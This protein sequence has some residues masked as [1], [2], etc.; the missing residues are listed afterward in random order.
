MKENGGEAR[1]DAERTGPPERRR[2]QQMS[3]WVL[4]I[5]LITPRGIAIEKVDGF[6]SEIFCQDAASQLFSLR[7][8]VTKELIPVQTRCIRTLTN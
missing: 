1:S 5:F 3:E 4:L 2:K 6:R 7:D 8:P